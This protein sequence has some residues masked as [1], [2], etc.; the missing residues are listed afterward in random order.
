MAP[1]T[2]DVRDL[3]AAEKVAL[4]ERLWES[5]SSHDDLAEPPAWHEAVLKQREAEWALRDSVSQ[6]WTEAKKEMR[7]RVG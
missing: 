7:D 2:L 6:D 4:M 1:E 5:L 3:S